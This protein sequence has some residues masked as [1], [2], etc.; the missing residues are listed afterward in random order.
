M[1]FEEYRRFDA[2]G[3]AEL[4][5]RGEVSPPEL[6]ETAIE[7]S[8]AV[9]PVINAVNR[10][11]HDLARA[12]ADTP[13]SGPFAGVPF[14]IKD[15]LQD[16]AGVPT[17]GGSRSLMN[18][19]APAHS[20]VVNRWLGAGLVV[21]GKT[22]APE[23]GVKV[24]TEPS[25]FGP[26]RNPWNPE[27]TPGGSS[28]GSAAAVAAG[29]VPAAGAN[30]GGGSIRIPAACCGLVGL[31]PGRGLISSGSG[32][33]LYGAATQGVLTRSVRDSA[34]MLDVLA[35][36]D[37]AGPYLPAVPAEKYVE[38]LNREPGSLRI[39]FT[40]ASPVG[41]VHP[42]AIAAVE[43][44]A[45]L[46]ESLGHHVEQADTGIDE[47]AVLHGLAWTMFQGVAADVEDARRRTGSGP[48]G[49]EADTLLSAALAR[50]VKA[51]ELAATLHS[52]SEHARRLAA[53]H[54][55]Y[56]LL[57][58]PTLASPPVQIG[59][60]DTPTWM[61]MSSKAV[62]VLRLTR[63]LVRT[64]QVDRV[65]DENLRMTPY[66]PLAN[67]TGRPAISVPLHWT[68]DGLPL[69]VQFVGPLGGEALLLSLA[70]QLEAAR[71]WFDRVPQ[72]SVALPTG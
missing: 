70:A 62:V 63:L 5:A 68:A 56:D 17:S 66:T 53:F 40:T 33:M 2:V 9:N 51:P 41:D 38:A 39:G 14:L 43:D 27:Y 8:A 11:M 10:P 19:P 55:R 4:V 52:W 18:C 60:L 25:A 16:Y 48:D 49:F 72:E 28:G 13:L 54:S 64:G 67:V 30:D 34:A 61:Q 35:G 71:P 1:D 47:R 44:A 65:I 50:T 23:F 3:L 31:K 15:L 57:L 7:R 12:R 45:R 59:T 22:S 24:V 46:L 69:G 20:E 36:P 42:E 26:T 29:I 6:L 32:E 21:F 58:T 37:P